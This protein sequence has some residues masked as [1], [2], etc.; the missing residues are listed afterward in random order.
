MNK[1]LLIAFVSFLSLTGL[2]FAQ[3]NL[4]VMT[5]DMGELYEKYHVA[6]AARDELN[7]NAQTAEDELNQMPKAYRLS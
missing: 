2:A 4:T 6:K 3:S 1:K 7:F 5:V